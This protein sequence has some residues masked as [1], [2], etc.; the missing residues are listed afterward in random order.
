MRLG[1]L[2]AGAL[3][4]ALWGG[5][6]ALAPHSCAQA[7]P[8]SAAPRLSQAEA[9]MIE[10]INRDVNR[11]P[12]GTVELSDIYDY[13]WDCDNYVFEKER[14][15]LARGFPAARMVPTVVAT[16]TGEAHIIL[17]IDGVLALDNRFIWTQSVADLK[18]YGYRFGSTPTAADLKKAKEG[19]DQ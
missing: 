18:R 4:A 15:L 13:T 10:A 9:G 14:R 7:A 1:L 17:V 19:P 8:V 16:E 12:Y 11:H 3:N 2:V 6:A 5:L